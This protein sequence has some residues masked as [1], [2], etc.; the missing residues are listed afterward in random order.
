MLFS[1]EECQLKF[2]FIPIKGNKLKVSV[3]L[4][5]ITMVFFCLSLLK[6]PES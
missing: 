3:D 5:I 6:I 2:H 1:I 4:I